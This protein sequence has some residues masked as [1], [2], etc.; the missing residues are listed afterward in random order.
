M[1]QSSTPSS[2][3]SQKTTIQEQTKHVIYAKC[4]S[5]ASHHY[6]REE[7]KQILDNIEP[8]DGPSI[9]LPDNS[10]ISV[11]SQG[12]LPLAESLSP[13]AKNAM[14][15]PGLKSASLISIGQL[16]DDGCNVLL[17]NRKLYAMKN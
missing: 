4:D 16:C 17:N 12:Q 1:F 15:L 6:W 10:K 9:L 8:H 13:Q 7:D 2:V 3:V 5:A 11:T 14:I